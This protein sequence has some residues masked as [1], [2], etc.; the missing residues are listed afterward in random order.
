MDVL[1]LLTHSSAGA[2]WGGFHSLAAPNNA[3]ENA[4]VKGFVWTHV[5]PSLGVPGSGI[6]G[7]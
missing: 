1:H 2:H 5:F 7:S 4:R 6:T 3:A